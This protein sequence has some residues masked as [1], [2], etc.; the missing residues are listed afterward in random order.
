MFPINEP[1]KVRES[2]CLKSACSP[3]SLQVFVATTWGFLTNVERAIIMPS[4]WLYLKTEWDE[5][6]A[7]KFY[8]ATVAVFCL[9]ILVFTPLVGYA[10]YK[11]VRTQIILIVSNQLEILGNIMYL[12]GRSPWALLFGRLISGLGA[13]C[14]SPLYSDMVKLTNERERTFY[15]MINVYN[16]P[17][18][19][20]ASL[21]GVHCIL[22]L[23]AYPDMERTINPTQTADPQPTL[24]RR[25]Q[26][27]FYVP[28]EP[29]M[30]KAVTDQLPPS[31]QPPGTWEPEHNA[32]CSPCC[33]RDPQCLPYL[34]YFNLSLIALFGITFFI[35]YCV[36]GLEAVLPPV[37][38]QL[39]QWTEIEVSIVYLIAGGAVIVTFLIYQ[40]ITQ[41]IRDR[42][43][44]AV[45]LSL[46]FF[47]YLALS[48]HLAHKPTPDKSI[49]IPFILF[50]V[51]LHVIGVPLAAA[52]SESLYTKL[53]PRADVERGQTIFRTVQNLGFSAGPFICASLVDTP[54]IAF[55]IMMV[56]VYVPFVIFW[57]D[58]HTFRMTEDESMKIQDI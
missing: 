37:T 20:M 39:Y 29:R 12:V 35:Y 53:V 3:K 6:A 44:L 36:M 23:L 22:T 1:D 14:D 26:R 41:C 19:L 24:A 34:P 13:C 43:V 21:W 46:L 11:G 52:S 47:A 25:L 40:C 55:L 45:G 57:I 10:T 18:L 2:N 38:E 31:K 30:R 54:Y 4:L 50:A 42:K 48:C 32:N 51:A 56:L 7:K 16:V 27:I 49:G 15:V 5:A 8:A 17:G 28:R 9:A 33:A 58:Y